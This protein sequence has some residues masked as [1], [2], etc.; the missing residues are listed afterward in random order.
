MQ[1][2][3]FKIP[4]DPNDSQE[5]IDIVNTI[6]TSIA[7]QEGTNE[8]SIVKI[9]NWF[10]HKWLNYSGYG[11]IPF[12]SGGLFE[13]DAAKEPKWNDNITVPPFNP[14]R[15]IWEKSYFMNGQINNTFLRN[16]H[17][18]QS[19][20]NNLN[21]RIISKSKKGLFIWY[22][23]NSEIN[24]KGSLMIYITNF[25]EI[26]TWYASFDKKIDWKISKTKGIPTK[27][28]IRKLNKETCH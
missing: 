12:E 19:S 10:D 5:F 18:N 27:E 13:I 17:K 24:K 6:A 9:K 26:K 1:K 23:S 3:L 7:F 20:H 22:S 16:L 25:N 2:K 11:V 4:I 15:I 21:N 28:L 14:N 8:I